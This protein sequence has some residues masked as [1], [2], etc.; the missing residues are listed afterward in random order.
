M[1]MNKSL[2]FAL[3]NY[4]WRITRVIIER[5]DVRTILDKAFSMVPQLFVLFY[6]S[7]AGP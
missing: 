4:S 5:T 7:P 3:L 6:Q 2:H 1:I